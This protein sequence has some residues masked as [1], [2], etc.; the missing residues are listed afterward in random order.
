MFD[1]QLMTSH[2]ASQRPFW[3][4]GHHHG[5]HV[6]TYGFLV[7]EL[8][9][10]RTGLQVGAALREFVTG[11]FDIDYHIGLAPSEHHRVAD[12][13]S[14][15]ELPNVQ[16]LD[17]KLLARALDATGDSE[18]DLMLRHTYF[19][20]VGLS[21]LGAVNTASW[22]EAEIPS[23]NSHGTA[24]GVAAT[25]SAFL[26]G[27]LVGEGVRAQALTTHSEGEDFII[28]R[29]SRFGLGFQLPLESRPIGPNPGSFGHFGY[30]GSLGFADPETGVAF[31]YLMNRPGKRWQTPRVKNL[32][33][34]TAAAVGR[35]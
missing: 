23:T 34:A 6:N 7:G 16:D 18:R 12:F 3:Q 27:G 19:N 8:V 20:P 21:G 33:D 35:G 29:P 1:W 24:R 4:P 9:R 30:G 22:R 17:P 11:R 25:Y 10:R 14:P 15:H 2:L 13:C 32:I 28:G 31:G 26:N 5:Y